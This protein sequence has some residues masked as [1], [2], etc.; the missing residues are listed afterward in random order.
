MKISGILKIK[1]MGKR[2]FFL[3]KNGLMQKHSLLFFYK[4]PV[5]LGE[6]I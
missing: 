2:V 6:I 5:I 1:M 4:T 3:D